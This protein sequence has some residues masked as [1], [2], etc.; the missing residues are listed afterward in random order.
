MI[1]G[2]EA[3][4]K[5]IAVMQRDAAYGGWNDLSRVPGPRSSSACDTTS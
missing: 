4:D 5:I 2:N 3:D 1:D